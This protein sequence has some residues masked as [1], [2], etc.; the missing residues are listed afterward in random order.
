MG[1]AVELLDALDL[2]YT[3]PAVVP[4]S[5]GNAAAAAGTGGGGATG[6]LSSG[7]RSFSTADFSA[8]AGSSGGVGARG[9]GGGG[10]GGKGGSGGGQSGGGKARKAAARRGNTDDHVGRSFSEEL[11]TGTGGASARRPRKIVLVGHSMGGLLAANFAERY[12]RRVSR[13]ILVCPAGTPVKDMW[14][15]SLYL[16]LIHSAHWLG[17]LPWLGPVVLDAATDFC[18]RLMNLQRKGVY[19]A[20][21]IKNN[22]TN[23]SN[24]S[25]STSAGGRGGGGGGGGKGS[26]RAVSHV[27]RSASLESVS[28]L[29]EEGDEETEDEEG[30]SSVSSSSYSNLFGLFGRGREEER[31]RRRKARRITKGY[32]ELSQHMRKLNRVSSK[33]DFRSTHSRFFHMLEMSRIGWGF[34]RKQ[35]NTRFVRA[36]SSILH[37][38]DL[39]GDWTSVFAG[40]AYQGVPA[41]V[42]WGEED[43]FI[44]FENLATLR[45][46]MVRAHEERE[47]ARA[48]RE[49]AMAALGGGGG[50]GGGGG[51]GKAI[52]GF[53]GRG[54]TVAPSPPPRFLAFQDADHFIFL[55]R[56][57]AFNA[58]L[59]SFLEET[60]AAVLAAA[61][62]WTT[63]EE[64]TISPPA[65]ATA[66]AP[67]AARDTV[68][69]K[70][71]PERRMKSGLGTEGD[72]E[73]KRGKASSASRGDLLA[74]LRA[75][76]TQ[77]RD[78]T[79]RMAGIAA[80]LARQEEGKQVASTTL[81]SKAH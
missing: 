27:S 78:M 35:N 75:L 33:A 63:A 52:R 42:L 10:G 2:S 1:Q 20:L 61:P 77:A 81:A 55:N 37:N 71:Q 5:G 80:E 72:S 21:G 38:L 53:S 66:T 79:A 49:D 13:L 69:E 31:R 30:K 47:G 28:E 54:A 15:K 74:E 23:S 29:E 56:P 60:R 36:L 62:V 44:P 65:A 16:N 14:K 67:A 24:A 32:A 68:E 76:Q 39:F 51:R 59:L 8:G 40:V 50:G 43:E 57:Q 26:A 6:A 17:T 19:A 11:L 34:Q 18:E 9:R 22:T 7:F 70:Q 41:M 25:T 3:Y 12:P 4:S 45:E 73:S 58:A 64:E 46:V 48:A